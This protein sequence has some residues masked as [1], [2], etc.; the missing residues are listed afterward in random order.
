MDKG[1]LS[2]SPSGSGSGARE[3]E[4]AEASLS[5]AGDEGTHG[6][7]DRRKARAPL[8]LSLARSLHPVALLV[9]FGKCNSGPDAD[10]AT[11][12]APQPPSLVISP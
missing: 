7:D 2:P 6:G 5:F 9:K 4:A 11:E 12:D 3:G 1:V 8:S 10:D